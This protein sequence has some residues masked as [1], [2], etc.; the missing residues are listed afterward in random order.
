METVLPCSVAWQVLGSMLWEE[1][2]TEND[3][4]VMFRSFSFLGSGCVLHF[5]ILVL[6]VF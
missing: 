2:A 6:F 5:L 1:D 4:D 3:P